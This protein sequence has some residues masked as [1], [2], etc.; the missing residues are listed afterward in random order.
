[1]TTS[2]TSTLPR[3]EQFQEVSSHYSQPSQQKFPYQTNQLNP[4]NSPS[5][6]LPNPNPSTTCNKKTVSTPLSATTFLSIPITKT[7]TLYF[8]SPSSAP[9]PHLQ[10]AYSTPPFQNLQINH[11]IIY[12]ALIIVALQIANTL[13]EE[14]AIYFTRA[15]S[16]YWVED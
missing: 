13:I 5:H 8:N 6:S 15:V 4:T 3:D 2:S 9:Y 16:F 14:F 7:S 10:T 1:M 12:N 11:F